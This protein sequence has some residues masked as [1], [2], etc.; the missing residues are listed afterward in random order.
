[1]PRRKA[2]PFKKVVAEVPLLDACEHFGI[3]LK[4]TGKTY[5]GQ[6]P[7]CDNKRM[8]VTPG[9]GFCCH[10]CDLQGDVIALAKAVEDLDSMY[11]AAAYLV[12]AFDLSFETTR[13]KRTEPKEKVEEPQ[14]SED[15]GFRPLTYLKPDHEAVIALGFDP[16]E[17]EELGVGYAPRGY[18][19]QTVAIPVRKSDGTLVGYIGV[20]EAKL[21]TKWHF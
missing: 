8:A 10:Q 20:T 14:S 16:D 4:K 13:K 12:D 17:A 21:P 2:I 19:K 5:R 7:E 18:H 15:K 11:E 6:C 1:M 3:D 9:E